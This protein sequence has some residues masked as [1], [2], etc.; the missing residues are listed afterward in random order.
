MLKITDLTKRYKDLVAV[1][2]ITFSVQPGEIFGFLG[3]NGAGKTTTINCICGLLTPDSGSIAIDQQD[4][5]HGGSKVRRLLGVVPQEVALYEEF[6][7]IENLHFWGGLYGLK[8]KKLKDRIQT[9]LELT[10]LKDRAKDAVSTYSGPAATANTARSSVSSTM[11]NVSELSV[12]TM[13]PSHP[14]NV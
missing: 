5:I 12:A 3:P 9:L 1:D 13:S 8:T 7:A 2:K 4:V 14:T 10:G 6:N 11:V